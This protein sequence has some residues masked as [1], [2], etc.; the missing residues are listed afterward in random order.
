MLSRAGTSVL[1]MTVDMNFDAHLAR[2]SARFAEA[3]GNARPNTPVPTCPKW[4]ADDLGLG[5][6]PT[7]PVPECRPISWVESTA[8]ERRSV[9]PGTVPPSAYQLSGGRLRIAH[10]AR[11]WPPRAAKVCRFVPQV[12]A[13]RPR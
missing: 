3:L 12:A 8:H 11:R 7:D 13:R 5:S 1:V 10:G 9:Q 4:D 6:V 2:E